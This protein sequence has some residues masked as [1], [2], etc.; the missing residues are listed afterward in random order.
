[1]SRRG[2]QTAQSRV[3]E[4]QMSVGASSGGFGWTLEGRF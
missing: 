4:C 1:L 2:E 3:A